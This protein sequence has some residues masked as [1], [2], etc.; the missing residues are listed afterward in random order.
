MTKTI[1][2]YV[3]DE[4][5]KK[6]VAAVLTKIQK[7]LAKIDKTVHKNVLD[8]FSA[9]FDASGRNLTMEEWLKEEKSR[10]LQK[11][12]QNAIGYFHQQILGSVTGWH[13]PGHNGGYD[14]GNEAKKIIAEIKNKWNT[15]NSSSEAEA[16]NKMAKLLDSKKKDY[17]GYVVQIIPKTPERYKEKFA[18]G[19]KKVR[20]DLFLVD[21][22]TYYE[23]VTG[24]KNALRKL[25]DTLH[26]TI[27]VM[28][29][30]S[31]NNFRLNEKEFNALFNKA[32][33]K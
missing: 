26:E 14:S 6:E 3:E 18:P 22:A 8:P 7:S 25:Y 29:S 5:F 24:D 15:M 32:Y 33:G 16:Y 9:I 31:K 20:K 12:L 13:N 27:R 30:I 10:Q 23:L 28:R 17:T 11:T 2:P 19:E 4:V 1:F 21:G